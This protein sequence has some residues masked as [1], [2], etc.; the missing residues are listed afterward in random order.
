M[1]GTGLGLATNEP[2][3]FG[4]ATQHGST[5]SLV[6]DLTDTSASNDPSGI[7]FTL[8]SGTT[9]ADLKTLSTNFDPTVGGCGG[10][11]PRRA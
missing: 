5:V 1:T 11:S 9:F 10:G 8:P 4:G 3:T 7:A 6:S 2:E